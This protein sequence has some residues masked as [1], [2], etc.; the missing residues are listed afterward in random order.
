MVHNLEQEPDQHQ[1][2]EDHINRVNINSI[3]FNSKCSLITANLETLSNQVNIIIP[4]KVDI[5]SDG[6]IV[7]LHIYKKL[8]PRATK[9]LLLMRWNKKTFNYKQIMEQ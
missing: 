8:F 5:G 2:E 4:Y 7:P 6:N 3:N 1:E 9:E